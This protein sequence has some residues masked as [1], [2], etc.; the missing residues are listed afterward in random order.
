MIP[1]ERGD[2]LGAPFLSRCMSMETQR[3][4]C[5]LVPIIL[6]HFLSGNCYSRSLY[7]GGIAIVTQVAACNRAMMI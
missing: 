6:P 5:L 4:E 1:G 2:S 7:T 3:Q